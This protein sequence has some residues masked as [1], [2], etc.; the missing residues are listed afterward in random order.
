MF[1]GMSRPKLCKGECRTCLKCQYRTA[2]GRMLRMFERM[3]TLNF[4]EE[5]YFVWSTECQT[6]MALR[7]RVPRM[8]ER[9]GMPNLSEVACLRGRIPGMFEGMLRPNLC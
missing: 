1:D 9:T 8:F 2:E 7:G 6:P 5:E 3:R 4:S